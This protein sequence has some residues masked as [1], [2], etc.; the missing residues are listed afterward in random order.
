MSRFVTLTVVEHE[1]NLALSLLMTRGVGT[2]TQRERQVLGANVVGYE[3]VPSHEHPGRP[4]ARVFLAN[5]ATLYV[6]EHVST[7]AQRVASATQ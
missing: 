2:T 5:G 4:H 6:K 1:T 7:V 3:G